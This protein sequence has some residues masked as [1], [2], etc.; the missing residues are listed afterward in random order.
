VSSEKVHITDNL[1]QW[2]YFSQSQPW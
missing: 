1:Y 2:N